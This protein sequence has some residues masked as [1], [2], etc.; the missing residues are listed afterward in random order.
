[1]VYSGKGK[2][3]FDPDASIPPRRAFV[4][5]LIEDLAAT[6]YRRSQAGF[7]ARDGETLELA[8][9]PPGVWRTQA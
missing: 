5:S 7:A 1:M 9:E 8:D 4:K 2:Q 3:A 6:G